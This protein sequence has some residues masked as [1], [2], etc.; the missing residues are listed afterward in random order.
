M[1]NQSKSVDKDPFP[2]NMFCL[3]Q[4]SIENQTCKYLYLVD[5]SSTFLI[6]KT[7]V[8]LFSM[9]DFFRVHG[10]YTD[11]MRQFYRIYIS[12]VLFF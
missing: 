11:I 8:I 9:S 5:V 7:Y 3:F 2:K 6:M 1:K 10:G 4:L 12:S